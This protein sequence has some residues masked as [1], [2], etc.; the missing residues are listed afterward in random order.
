MDNKN[1]DPFTVYRLNLEN[2]DAEGL[3]LLEKAK[4]DDKGSIINGDDDDDSSADDK[5]EFPH[6]LDPVKAET[7]NIVKDLIE[8]DRQARTAKIDK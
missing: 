4:A 1:G 7:I 3:T 8:I 2:V 5:D 6:D